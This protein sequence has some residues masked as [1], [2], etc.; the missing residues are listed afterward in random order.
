VTRDDGTIGG[1]DAVREE[2]LVTL[3]HEMGHHF[4]LDEDDLERLGY[5]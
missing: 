3:L 4:G 2:I 1:E 5:A